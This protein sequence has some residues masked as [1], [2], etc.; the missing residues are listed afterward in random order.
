VPEV[1]AVDDA[2]GL[3]LHL[4]RGATQD[5]AGQDGAD[6]VDLE[7][8]VGESGRR[9]FRALVS[10][11]EQP[12]AAVGVGPDKRPVYHLVIAARKDPAT[13]ALVDYLS[14]GEWRDI[15]ATYLDHMGLAPRGD[16]LGCRWVAVRHADDHVHV[17]VTLARQDGRRVFPRNDYYRAGEASRMVKA[18]YGLATPRPATGPRPSARPAPR[19]R[20]PPAAAGPS[21]S[22]TSCAAKCAPPPPGRPRWRSS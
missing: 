6:A 15:A 19:R 12:L 10:L 2:E 7:P 5:A 13:G 18:R 20:R 4:H 3:R 8:T 11:L 14:D 9:D 17:V 21:R 22:G 1:G 16:E